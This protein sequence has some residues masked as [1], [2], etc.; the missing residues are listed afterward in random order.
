MSQ[1][2]PSEI[3]S[4]FALLTP[5]PW[6]EVARMAPAS[7]VKRFFLPSCD[8]LA[9]AAAAHEQLV[10]FIAEARFVE[11]VGGAHDGFGIAA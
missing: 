8:D 11:V 1:F 2:M 4:S 5:H 6:S 10:P 3:A 7:R 9:V